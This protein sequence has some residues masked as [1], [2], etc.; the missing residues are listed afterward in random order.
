[1]RYIFVVCLRADEA[2]K[3]EY[4]LN[5]DCDAPRYRVQVRQVT[6]SDH[7]SGMLG[8][9]V[10]V[11]PSVMFLP[12]LRHILYRAS[13][14]HQFVVWVGWLEPIYARIPVVQRGGLL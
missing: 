10:H 8:A 6:R 12:D 11:L 7:L 9:T 1:M 14:N 3:H 13:V 5:K 2:M 4:N